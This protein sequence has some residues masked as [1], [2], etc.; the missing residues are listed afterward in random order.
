MVGSDDRA[1]YEGE[2]FTGR[3]TRDLIPPAEESQQTPGIDEVNESQGQ[4]PAVRCQNCNLTARSITG[5][6]LWCPRCRRAVGSRAL[7]TPILGLL[8]MMLAVVALLFA[9][10]LYLDGT[11]DRR[12]YQLG[13]NWEPCTE[14]SFWRQTLCGNQLPATNGVREELESLF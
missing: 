1:S 2:T 10:A 11:F 5:G 3:P 12:L 8:V 6:R 14:Q 13:L 7:G 4:H 9:G